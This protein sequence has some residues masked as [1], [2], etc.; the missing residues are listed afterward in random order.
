M[1]REQGGTGRK[2]EAGVGHRGDRRVG[3]KERVQRSL[4]QD[5]RMDGLWIWKPMWSIFS[6]YG[7]R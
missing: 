1:T 6:G 7:A 4:G 3:M 2:W 5:G